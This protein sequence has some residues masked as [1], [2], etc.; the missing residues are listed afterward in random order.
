MEDS[1]ELLKASFAHCRSVTRSH[2][3]SFHFASL[4]LPPAKKDAASAVYAY[5]R[6]ADDL[7]DEKNIG[8]ETREASLDRLDRDFDKL[9]ETSGH[10]LDF[11]PAFVATVRRYDIPKQYF[12]DLVAGVRMD[13]EPVRVADWESL[14]TYCY[15]VASVVGLIMCRIFE[16]RAVAGEER[17]ID[18][19]IAMQLTNILRDIRED[20]DNGRV[21]IP[22]TELAAFNV[23]ESD[24]QARRMTPS[25]VELMRFQVD[26][27]RDFY[28]RSEPGIRLLAD[29]GSQLTV[30]LMREVYAGILD[31]IERVQYDVWSGRVATSSL[32]KLALA[33]RAWWKH[34][35]SKGK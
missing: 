16:L 5:C 25:F 26:R 11:G 18:L 19:G 24:L 13:R 9:M 32:R 34:Q 10:G 33:G 27:A 29:D 12:L 3:R 21:Y 7:V 20:L 14:R 6:H 35:L 28:K 1:L 2:A 15:H 8:T 31:E 30:W 4:A 22:A 17:A 23:A